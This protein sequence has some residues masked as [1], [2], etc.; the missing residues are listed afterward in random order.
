MA[1]IHGADG[2]PLLSVKVERSGSRVFVQFNGELD[3]STAPLLQSTLVDV[4]G[5]SPRRSS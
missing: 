1:K 2:T 4:L 3:L 5:E